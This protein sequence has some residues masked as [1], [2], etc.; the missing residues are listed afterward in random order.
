MLMLRSLVSQLDRCP[1]VTRLAQSES[2]SAE[3]IATEAADS[4]VDIRRSAETLTISLLPRLLVQQP[5][6]VEF[7]DTLDDIAEELRHIYYHIVNTKLFAYVVP[8]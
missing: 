5:E 3:E 6:S 7:E 4:L 2:T 1:R 8:K